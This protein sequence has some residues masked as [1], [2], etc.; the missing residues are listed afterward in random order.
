MK[1]MQKTAE[2]IL[3]H[4]YGHKKSNDLLR[5]ALA[6]FHILQELFSLKKVVLKVHVTKF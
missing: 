3:K 1:I 4:N 5:E 2:G 6:Y